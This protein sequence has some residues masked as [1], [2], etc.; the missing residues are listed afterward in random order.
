[1][2]YPPSP[3]LKSSGDLLKGGG[4]K[5]SCGGATCQ[6]AEELKHLK[7]QHEKMATERVILSE[8]QVSMAS[9]SVTK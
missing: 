4:V 5:S 1:M 7:Q 8:E 3:S 9:F 6:H 2:R